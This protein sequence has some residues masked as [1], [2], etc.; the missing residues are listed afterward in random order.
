VSSASDALRRG[1]RPSGTDKRAT[2]I[3]QLSLRKLDKSPKADRPTDRRRC[4]LHGSLSL[5]SPVMMMPC[6]R[7]PWESER[8]RRPSRRRRRRRNLPIPCHAQ[9]GVSCPL[10]PACP[11]LPGYSRLSR[12]GSVVFYSARPVFRSVLSPDLTA[13]LVMMTM[14][15]LLLPVDS[16]G[17]EVSAIY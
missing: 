2:T 8:A 1:A 10:P 6:P 5:S 3:A 12:L 14:M 7:G 4:P 17:G 16:I 15:R 11:A 13:R 9:G